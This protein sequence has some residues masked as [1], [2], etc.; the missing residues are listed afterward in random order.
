MVTTEQ[1]DSEYITA[2]KPPRP[3]AGLQTAERRARSS[4]VVSA[5]RKRDRNTCV[6]CFSAE[7][8]EVHHIHPLV[9]GGEDTANNCVCVCKKC[10]DHAPNE[11][12]EF[13]NYQRMGGRLPWD[14]LFTLRRLKAHVP[15]SDVYHAAADALEAAILSKDVATISG[16]SSTYLSTRW[17]KAPDPWCWYEQ[18]V[19]RG[20]SLDGRAFNAVYDYAVK[21]A[22]WARAISPSLPELPTTKRRPSILVKNPEKALGFLQQWGAAAAQVEALYPPP[23]GGGFPIYPLIYRHCEQLAEALYEASLELAGRPQ[24]KSEHEDAEE[25][26]G[27]IATLQSLG[28]EELQ[29]TIERLQG[30]LQEAA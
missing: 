2:L 5:V 9:F 19:H 22:D 23:P 14:L 17:Y 21:F 30:Q 3:M 7:R 12:E 10:H 20:G 24:E 26:K 15:S 29:P 1:H 27:K 18:V 6:C 4:K 11:P 13:L 28:F 25:I 16:Y 8:V